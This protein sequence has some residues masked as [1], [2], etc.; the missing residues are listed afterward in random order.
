MRSL[1][2]SA[3]VFHG[4]MGPFLILGLRMGLM[5]RRRLKPRAIHDM[6]VLVWTPPMPPQSCILDGIQVASGCTLGKGNIR[7][8]NSRVIKAIFRKGGVFVEIEPS[9]MVKRIVADVSIAAS[10]MELRET[11]R[12]L[13]SLPD[14][15]LLTVKVSRS[16]RPKK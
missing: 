9:E 11:A 16:S 3:E 15:Q 2:K 12:L 1:V 6:T 7:M 13:A 10:E 8:R 4:H 14:R 5:A